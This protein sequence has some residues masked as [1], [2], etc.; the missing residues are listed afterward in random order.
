MTY[1]VFDIGG[2]ST[3]VAKSTDLR[4]LEDMRKFNTPRSF[5]E[6]IA[7]V[8]AAAKDL[9]GG[10]AAEGAAGGIRGVLA[11]D[12]S[13]LL[14]E[15]VL[16]DW[17]GK[18][19]RDSLTEGFGV[20][21]IIE[22]D[23]VL[24]GAGEAA[25]GAGKGYPIVAYHTVSTGV[26]G[27]RIVDGEPD[28]AA[29]NF[30]PGKMVIDPDK[31]LCPDCPGNTLES[32]VSGSAVEARFGKKPYEIP[33][34]DPLWAELAKWLAVGLSTTVAYWSPDVIVLGGSMI[35][36]EPRILREDV[37]RELKELLGSSMPLPVIADAHH[38]DEAGLYGGLALLARPS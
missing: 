34:S 7:A 10:E 8:V 30:E 2:T 11:H 18:P 19:I 16:T 3:R 32:Y 38:R 26:G 5:E 6:G 9:L 29:Y 28:P 36:G 25:F 13:T 31:T 22:N 20:T 1:I 12:R 35:L 33:Q 17:V 4:T 14:S 37:E 24:A 27:A 23:A 21:P 15:S